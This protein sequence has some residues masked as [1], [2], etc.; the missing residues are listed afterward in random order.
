MRLIVEIQAVADQLFQLDFRRSFGTAAVEP[1]TFSALP[2]VSPVSATFASAVPATIP[3]GAV[4][5]RTIAARSGPARA[6]SLRAAAAFAR[7]TAFLALFLLLFCHVL[8][9]CHQSG[10]FQ[11][12]QAR[13]AQFHFGR[14]APDHLTDQVRA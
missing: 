13:R 12:Y 4:A 6:P 2:A 3:A 1:A 9:L 8:N 7:W 10:P 5:A 14:L 11:G